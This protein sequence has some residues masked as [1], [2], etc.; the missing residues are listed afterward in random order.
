MNSYVVHSQSK[1]EL[2]S[3]DV[4]RL[5]TKSTECNIEK[6]LEEMELAVDDLRKS[7]EFKK[8]TLSRSSKYSEASNSHPFLS[9]YFGRSCIISFSL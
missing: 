9:N 8:K 4:Q 6:T 7:I 1:I 3:F 5:H 2:G